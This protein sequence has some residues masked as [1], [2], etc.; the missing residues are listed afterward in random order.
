MDEKKAPVSS[1]AARLHVM[2]ARD[3][4]FAVILRRG[5]PK[6]VCTI[7]WHLNDDT[8]QVG[9]WLKGRV[10]EHFCDLSPDGEH[11]L[12][13]ADKYS[14]SDEGLLEYTVLSRAP[15]LKALKIWKGESFYGGV[16]LSNDRFALHEWGSFG[17]KPEPRI[18]R[19][20]P[21]GEVKNEAELAQI[22]RPP[23]AFHW[24]F[25]RD[26]W[27]GSNA[28]HTSSSVEWIKEFAGWELKWAVRGAGVTYAVRGRRLEKTFD[29][30]RWDWADFRGERLLWA[31]D[32]KIF[33][34]QIGEDG[35]GPIEELADFNNWTFE[36]I[37]A[38]Y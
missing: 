35:H 5:P 7:G 29:C 34:A 9:Q 17:S 13:R 32:G 20:A 24:R 4:P 19:V 23:H 14:S 31:Q 1:A 18:F 12:Y 33:A 25:E 36:P 2:L 15:H 27:K 16:F 38:P 3:A 22:E 21:F 37:A 28:L 11:L 10:D 8:F 6:Q 26:G 30:A